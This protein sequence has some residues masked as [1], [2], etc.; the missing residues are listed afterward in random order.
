LTNLIGDPKHAG[1][2]G[3]LRDALAAELK[4]TAAPAAV[5]AG[6]GPREKR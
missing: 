4:R 5:I 3:R 1:R 6:P 2:L